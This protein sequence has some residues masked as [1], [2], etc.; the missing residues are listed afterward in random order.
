[1]Q[2][3]G[4]RPDVQYIA[5]GATQNT[6]R[7]AQWMLKEAG[8]TA[9]MGCVGDDEYAAKMRSVCASDGVN[10]QYMVDTTVPTGT[11]AVCVVDSDRSLVANIAAANNYKVRSCMIWTVDCC[12]VCVQDVIYIVVKSFSPRSNLCCAWRALARRQANL[13]PQGSTHDNYR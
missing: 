1:L 7:V 6:V 8:A 9:Y 13:R 4:E 12:R 3:L 2:E 11:C 10:V 5:G